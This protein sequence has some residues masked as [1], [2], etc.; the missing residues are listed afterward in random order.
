MLGHFQDR[1]Q[2]FQGAVA[3]RL[4]AEYRQ[5]IVMIGDRGRHVIRQAPGLGR[6]VPDHGVVGIERLV[7]G[8][9][10]PAIGTGVGIGLFQHAHVV[11]EPLQHQRHATIVEQPQGI[12]FIA[13]LGAN[14][15]GQGQAGHRH[16]LGGV[17][18]PVQGDDGVVVHLALDRLRIDQVDDRATAQQIHR[19]LD[20]GDLVAQAVIRRVDDFQQGAR[21]TRVLG[22]QLRDHVQIRVGHVLLHLQIHHDLRLG[23]HADALQGLL[24]LFGSQLLGHKYTLWV[25]RRF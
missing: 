24:D 25:R 7:L 1:Q 8:V 23:R 19:A 22:N 18:E 14:A 11:G 20:R 13:G 9:H 17:P 15:L 21:E 5:G 4:V 10:H 16:V 6:V 12:G 2:V 3:R